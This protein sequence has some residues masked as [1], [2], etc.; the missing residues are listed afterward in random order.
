MVVPS[1]TGPVWANSSGR[2][3]REPKL[4]EVVP[5]NNQPAIPEASIA[6]PGA[7]S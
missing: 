1:E 7:F 5:P 4:D 2:F 6:R 3:P